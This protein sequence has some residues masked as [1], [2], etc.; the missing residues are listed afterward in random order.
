MGEA[1]RL[2]DAF[3]DGQVEGHASLNQQLA[4]GAVLHKNQELFELP[5]SEYQ[6]LARCQVMT[7][8]KS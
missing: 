1:Q 5:V 8:Q 6:S 7:Y 2:L 3:A 4:E